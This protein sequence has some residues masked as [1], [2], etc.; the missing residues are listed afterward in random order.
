MSGQF[1]TS[2]GS[3]LSIV[4]TVRNGKLRPITAFPAS[5]PD[6]TAFLEKTQ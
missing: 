2:G 3:L 4:F 5:A 6:K 1:Y